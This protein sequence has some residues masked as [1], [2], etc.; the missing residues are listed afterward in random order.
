MA[1]TDGNERDEGVYKVERIGVASVV[2]FAAILGPLFYI[3][4][5]FTIS[6]IIGIDILLGELFKM[7]IIYG[8]FGMSLSAAIGV[9]VF[10]RVA[11]TIGGITLFTNK[12][13]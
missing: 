10:N 6:S 1:T 2:K 4:I 7:A 3:A 12:L 13:E 9:V 5:N 8:A 11:S